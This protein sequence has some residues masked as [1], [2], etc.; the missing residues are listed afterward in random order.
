MRIAF[1][2]HLDGLQPELP[3]TRAGAVTLGPRGLLEVLETQLGLP[4][5]TVHPSAAA[6]GYLTCI[7]EADAPNRFYHRSLE[8]DEISVA[9]TLLAW[10]EQW[11]EAGWDGEF[12]DGVPSRLADMAA[13]EVLATER[14]PP[15]TGER[16]RRAEEAL[17]ERTTQI[18]RVEL[19]TA[20]EDF[21]H[22]WQ[23][24][25]EALPLASSPR[26]AL[27]AR[28]S[29]GSDLARVQTRLLEML[30]NEGQGGGARRET[31]RGDNSLVVVRAASRDLS[32]DAIA[33]SLLG[34]GEA[35]DTVIVA[36]HDGVVLDNAFERAGLPRSGFVHYTAFRAAL[37]VLKLALALVWEPVDPHRILTFLLH[38]VAPLPPWVRSRLAGAVAES[39]GIGGPKWVEALRRVEALQRER[40]DASDEDVL[41]LRAEI[42]YWL[43]GGRHEALAGAPLDALLERT[44]RISAWAATRLNTAESREEA[45]LFAASHAQC[46]ALL[47]GLRDL[48]R[49]RVPRLVLARLIDEVTT[50]APDPSIFAQVGR[51]RAT[52]SPGAVTRPTPTVIWWDLAPPPAG[53]SYPW[54][55][56]E[57][58]ALRAAG[59]RL[60]EVEQLVRRRSREWL[61]PILSA[62]ERLVLVVHEDEQGRHP[63][64]TQIEHAFDDLER[65]EVEPALLGGDSALGPLGVETRPLS[66]NPLPTPKRWWT[67]PE[68]CVLARRETESYSSLE[69]LCDHPHEWVL[70]YP[71]RLRAGRAAKV[72]DGPRLFGNLGH[73]LFEAFFETHEGWRNVPD[74]AV[75]RWVRGALPE[76]V[77]REGAVLLGPARGVDRQRVAATLERSLVGLLAHLRSA[78]VEHVSPEASREAPFEDCRLNGDIDLVLTCA[79]GERAV[80]DVK[81][82]N[83]GKRLALLVENRALQLA[84]YA[85]LQ[86]N[87][88]ADEG[89]PPGAFFILASSNVLASDALAFPDALVAPSKSGEGVPELWRRLAVTRRW[90]LAQ[91]ERGR[92]EVVTDRTAPDGDS[93]APEDG[94]APASGANPYD[95]FVHLTGWEDSL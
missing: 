43:E 1:G 65:V 72:M 47:A 81:W 76:I 93:T 4:T 83:E 82:A 75:R 53:V 32:A 37:Q 66:L 18:E 73:R 42:A 80:L 58:A 36:E 45:T 77:E 24:V 15:G 49:G 8:V 23:R 62:T 78:A 46:D 92:I 6:F 57:L 14:V 7:H 22:A 64:W 56:R 68:D 33:E 26:L 54:S 69:K 94:L 55:R 67:L 63:V 31:L 21:P 51:I 41:A 87:A 50:D 90:R 95:D 28:A 38:P 70:Q 10:R 59:V 52:A 34:P 25:L 2:H 11:F 12:P 27:E 29:V 13:V 44:D 89:W 40:Y 9:R 85:Y 3:G 88:D 84:T 71:A 79:G 17:A 20:F 35:A 5:P 74:E 30:E 91:L 16:L 39:P 19:H 48:G 60:P 86:K 61:R